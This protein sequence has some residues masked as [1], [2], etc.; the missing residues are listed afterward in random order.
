MTNSNAHKGMKKLGVLRTEN[1]Q[2]NVPLEQMVFRSQGEIRQVKNLMV[3]NSIGHPRH[4][5]RKLEPFVFEGSRNVLFSANHIIHL[6]CVVS[7]EFC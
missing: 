2:T 6:I 3:S 1:N 4:F 7:F 5:N